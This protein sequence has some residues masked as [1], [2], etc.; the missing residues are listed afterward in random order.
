MCLTPRQF[1]LLRSATQDGISPKDELTTADLRLL[2][3]AGLVLENDGGRF[4]QTAAGRRYV[5]A[6]DDRPDVKLA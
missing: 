4:S 1:E 6:G 5:E 3:R 2:A